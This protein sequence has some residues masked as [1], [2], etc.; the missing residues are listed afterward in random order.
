M[1]Y[2]LLGVLL[3]GLGLVALVAFNESNDDASN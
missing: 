2:V 3:V 1:M